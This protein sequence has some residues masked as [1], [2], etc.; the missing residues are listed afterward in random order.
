LA[1]FSTF[2]VP[3]DDSATLSLK[4]VDCHTWGTITASALFP[5]SFDD[6]LDDLGDLNPL[7][8]VSLALKFNGVGARVQVD[9]SAAVDGTVKL[10]LFV[11]ET[12]LGIAVS[13]IHDPLECL[14]ADFLIDPRYAN[15]HRIL[16]RLGIGSLGGSGDQCWLPS[17][18]AGFIVICTVFRSLQRRDC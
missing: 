11:S 2:K 6:L 8:D 15:R 7:N 16:C 12:P 3:N 4:C 1:Y 18:V 5:D 13:S 14:R 10:P 17:R 9:M